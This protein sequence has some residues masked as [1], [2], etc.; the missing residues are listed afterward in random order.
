[1]IFIAVVSLLI[2]SCPTPENPGN[3]P[4]TYAKEYWGEWLRMDATETWYIS[5][6][7]IKIGG[8]TSSKSVSLTK[9]SDRVV[10]VTDNGRKYY[11]YA[12]RVANASFTGKIAG[13][14]Q[15]SQSIQRSVAGGKGFL[16]V[17]VEDLNDKTNSVTT[18]TDADGNFTADG[19][20]PGDEYEV[21]PEGGTS[22]TVT[23]TGDGD[24]V[25]LIAI[26]N[27]VNFKTSIKS[28]GSNIFYANGTQY[29]FIMN[30]KNIGTE[31]CLAATYQL[32][33]DSGLITSAS[34]S[35]TVMGT[36][37]PGKDKTLNLTLACSAIS[38]E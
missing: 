31:D 2:L 32:S 22:I 16:K 18:T 28:S 36:I 12:S 33:F 26:S 30:I 34:T 8:T 35:Q 3:T 4:A 27:G 6:N 38:P 11:L 13:F 1:M 23:P 5:S 17:V 19:I 21:T 9:Q 14:E 7:A 15:P 20:I 37:E 29:N 25:G 24:D 10:E